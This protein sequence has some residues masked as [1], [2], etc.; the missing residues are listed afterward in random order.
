MV[1]EEGKRTILRA[2]P[3]TV[4]VFSFTHAFTDRRTHAKT[5]RDRDRDTHLSCGETKDK[6]KGLLQLLVLVCF[7]ARKKTGKK[8]TQA[9]LYLPERDT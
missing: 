2:L 9:L 8:P 1:S 4:S 3:G 7:Y 6:D 5:G